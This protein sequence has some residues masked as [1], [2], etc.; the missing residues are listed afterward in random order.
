M[1][2]LATVVTANVRRRRYGGARRIEGS[3]DPGG[4]PLPGPSVKL[5]VS[6]SCRH[7]YVWTKGLVVP[8]HESPRPED[9]EREVSCVSVQD[10]VQCS[11][12]ASDSG[13]VLFPARTCRGRDEVHLRAFVDPSVTCKLD[14]EARVPSVGCRTSYLLTPIEPTM[15]GSPLGTQRGTWTQPATLVS[16]PSTSV[17][18]KAVSNCLRPRW[19]GGLSLDLDPS[20]QRIV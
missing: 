8:P 5:G 3:V 2:R 4:G 11:K 13:P 10:R 19:S 20:H 1:A 14:V 16:V 6:S 17:P 9:A 7:R 12:D 18:E 15:R